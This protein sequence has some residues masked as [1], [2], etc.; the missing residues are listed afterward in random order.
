MGVVLVVTKTP[1][2]RR[3]AQAERERLDAS[4]VL[5]TQVLIEAEARQDETLG[6]VRATLAGCTVRERRVDQ[7]QAA[8]ADGIDL[9]VTV[10]GDGTVFSA[11]TLPTTVPYLTVNSDPER[12]VG[13]FTRFTAATIAAGVA[14]WES[15]S[16]ASEELPRLVIRVDGAEHRILNDCL[17]AHSNP[18]VLCRYVLEADGQREYQ[19]SSGVWISTAA[20]STAAIRSAGAE[21]VPGNP[22]ALLYRVRE[23]YQGRG[24]ACLLN[25]T[26][27]PPRGL[28]LVPSIPGMA[29]YLDG[30]NVTVAVAPG[31]PVD[32]ADAA[33][34]LRLITPRVG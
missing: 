32:I 1:L 34:P 4:G 5:P 9:V 30:P 24:A 12:S 27:L 31:I 33:Q 15:G 21:P 25:C 28:R 20:G 14:C 16:A 3:L 19:R 26:Q 22:P 13:H 7:L 10:G 11:N 29:L 18:A 2:A 17:F 6:T 23:P 8:D